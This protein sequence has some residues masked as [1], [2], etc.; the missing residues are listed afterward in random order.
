MF[1]TYLVQPLANGL[2]FFYRLLGGNLGWAIIVFTV[3]LRVV[4]TPLTKPYMD[5]MKRIKDLSGEVDKLKKKFKNDKVKFAQAQADLY[6][7]KG[8]NPQAG[9]LPY[10]FQ[11]LILIAFF[12]VF[13]RGFKDNVTES[14]NNMLYPKIAFFQ[15]EE[16]NTN[17]LYMD[18]S[19]PDVIRIPGVPIP[20]P[21]LFLVVSTLLQVAS[22]KLM[23]PTL[24]SEKKLAKKTPSGTDDAMLATQQS[25]T[26][27]FPLMTLF[28]GMS[29]PSG[30]ALYWTVFSLVQLV[31]QMPEGF[32]DKAFKRSALMVKSL[33]WKKK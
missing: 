7:Q 19:K 30:L 6:K 25:M 20:I 27:M 32:K 9:C 15:G 13:N 4:L 18:L 1:Y 33:P 16:I 22:M 31:Q 5:S 10:I 23:S 21:G 11:F 26:Y 12:N 8:V 28:F 24:K 2:I 29:F 14:F 3:L 17:F